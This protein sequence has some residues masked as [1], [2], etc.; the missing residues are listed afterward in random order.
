M[1]CVSPCQH[2]VDSFSHVKR[3]RSLRLLHL[4]LAIH[5]L[6]S[7]PRDHARASRRP[8][9][10]T[11]R[12]LQPLWCRTWDQ[13]V[14]ARAQELLL[15]RQSRARNRRASVAMPRQRANPRQARWRQAV[16]RVPHLA[17]LQA[18]VAALGYPTEPQQSHFRPAILQ[19]RHPASPLPRRSPVISADTGW[20]QQLL[21][22]TAAPRL[23]KLRDQLLLPRLRVLRFHSAATALALGQDQA[24]KSH[25]SSML[26]AHH[27]LRYYLARP[28]P[29]MAQHALC[30]RQ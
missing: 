18:T 29:A 25:P 27:A 2:G 9:S 5:G 11:P 15:Q 21:D 28:L 22:L 1:P 8:C 7:S 10:C 12:T 30:P 13:A 16:S 3:S 6:R 4:N 26:E 17:S 23:V 14:S 20:Q 24:H 19:A